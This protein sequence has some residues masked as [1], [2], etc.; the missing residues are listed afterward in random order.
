MNVSCCVRFSC[1]FPSV[2]TCAT[3]WS[4]YR[5][6]RTSSTACGSSPTSLSSAASNA[7]RAPSV[8]EPAS[9]CTRLSCKQLIWL[10]KN[11]CC[12]VKVLKVV[13]GNF[14]FTDISCRRTRAVCTAFFV[15]CRPRRATDKS[16]NRRQG[17]LCRRTA[18]MEH[19][20]DTAEAAAVDH[21]FS[22]PHVCSSLPTDTGIQTDDC[23]VMRPQSSV[24]GAIQTTQLQIQ[25]RLRCPSYGPPGGI[26]FSTCTSVC[27]CVRMHVRRAR[28]SVDFKFTFHTWH[29]CASCCTNGK[30][31]IFAIQFTPL[32]LK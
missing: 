31:V 3:T 10:F 20:A 4:R 23:F 29:I 30:L 7:S 24:V 12:N 15:V 18:S 22:P 6:A 19:A 21:Y 1:R 26:T 13:V 5:R 17:F 11:G 32:H 2:S 25:L 16:T 28:L 8:D 14:Y 9:C 27:A